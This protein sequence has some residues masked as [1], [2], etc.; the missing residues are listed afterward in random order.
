MAKFIIRRFFT[1]F[2]ALIA[3]TIVV[4]LISRVISDPAVLLLPMEGYGMD[5][6]EFEKM[7]DALHLN[8]NVVVQYSYWIGGI[9]KGDWGDDLATRQ[10]IA[11]K[12]KEKWWPTAQLALSAFILATVIGIP[13]GIF[14]AVKRGT[15]LDIGGRSFAVLGQSLPTFW[16]GIVGIFIFA[17]QLG[18][19]PSGTMGEGF[20]LNK[21]L[22]M[23]TVVLAW[24]PMAGYMRLVRS[25]M[26][27]V[28]DSEY[29]KLAR[30]KGVSQRSVIWKHGFRNAILAPLTFAGVLLAGLITGSIA[31]ETVFAWPGIARWAVEAVFSNNLTVLGAVTLVF[32]FAFIALNFIVDIL[33]A[34][35]D[36]RLRLT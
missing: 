7:K 18:W 12:L 21:N 23:P 10:P 30:S 3:S 24:L 15:Y 26:L 9:A 2:L 11:P 16:L 6:V 28:L 35:V 17:V 31:V 33:Y 14:S 8:D 22:I 36:P 29:I 19:L 1:S 5:P 4:F 13:L 34:F 27:D 20:F 32:T 25:A